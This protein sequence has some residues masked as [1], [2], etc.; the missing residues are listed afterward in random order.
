MK[1]KI[2]KF[3]VIL[4]IFFIL[5]FSFLRYYY[6]A[7]ERECGWNPLNQIIRGK[8]NELRCVCDPTPY[9]DNNDSGIYYGGFSC[10]NCSR[11]CEKYNLGMAIPQK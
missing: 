2:I 6:M 4:G 5:G 7:T 11:F 10:M 9:I 8:M 3:A 1:Q